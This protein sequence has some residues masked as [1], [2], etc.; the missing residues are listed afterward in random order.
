MK[1]IF[2]TMEEQKQDPRKGKKICITGGLGFIGSYAVEK[3][4]NEGWAV[5]VVDNKYSNAID[6]VP[7]GVR[8]FISDVLEFD[9]KAHGPYDVILHLASPVGPAGVLKWSGRMGGEI[10]NDCYW[11]IQAA[12]EHD[13][14]LVFYSTS[15]IY[16]HRDELC[17]LDEKADKVLVGDYKVRN[18]YAIGKL[19]AEII[20][21]NTKRVKPELRYTI[22]RPFN[23]SGARQQPDGGFVMPRFTKQALSGEPITVFGD[24]SQI[25][26]FTHVQDIVD[27]THRII[28]S[29]IEN[30]TWCVG[31]PLNKM[32]I[33]DI[34]KKIVELTGSNSEIKCVDPKEIYG[35]MYE[36]AWD[37]LP[38]SEKLRNRT[39]WYPS[40]GINYIIEDVVGYWME[41]EGPQ[42]EKKR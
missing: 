41:K 8:L 6:D 2:G 1:S 12:L 30:E 26:A 33:M 40:K 42:D 24:G 4:H 28:E 22:I 32:S 14:Q 27:G 7:E 25:R 18:E 16:G 3:F 20:I 11:G 35:P 5:D 19:L 21:S 15:E 17:F 36:E 37:K 38:D 34:A 23:I 29:G 9:H 39:G 31:N 13:A 10:I